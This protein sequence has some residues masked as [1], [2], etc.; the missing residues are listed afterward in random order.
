LRSGDGSIVRLSPLA[1]TTVV[2]EASAGHRFQL[3]QTAADRISVRLGMQDPGERSAAWRA[4]RS[5][6]RTY[7]DRQ[8]LGDIRLSLDRRAP[9]PDARSGKL[10][11]VVVSWRAAPPGEP[12]Q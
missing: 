9:E 1:L 2:E 4:T 3:R 8:N 7:L 11:E 12:G 5:A 6:L 10:R